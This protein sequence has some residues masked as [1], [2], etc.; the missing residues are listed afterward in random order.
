M[1]SYHVNT[2]PTRGG[3]PREAAVGFLGDG[4][5]IDD[6]AEALTGAGISGDR[7][8][9]L[10]GEDGADALETGAS[11][12]RRLFEDNVRHV[13]VAA[14]RSGTTIVAILGVTA[15]DREQVQTAMEDAGIG[16]RRYFGRGSHNAG[17]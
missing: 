16:H 6:V 13:P 10:Q 5:E 14:L 15:D 8:Y 2:L 3:L 12:I 11:A 4:A 17:N 7:L 1:P 9:F